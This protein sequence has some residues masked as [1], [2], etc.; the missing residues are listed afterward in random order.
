MALR[1]RALAALLEDPGAH[2]AASKLSVFP[3]SEESNALSGLHGL[4]AHTHC[5]EICMQAK[6]PRTFHNE[7]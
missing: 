6:H 4:Q 2:V 5:T 7:D 1:L 3:V